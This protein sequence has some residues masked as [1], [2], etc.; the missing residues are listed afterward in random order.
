MFSSNEVF[1]ILRVP[2]EE[3]AFK[4]RGAHGGM[5]VLSLRHS[6]FLGCSDVETR[7][8]ISTTNFVFNQGLHEGSWLIEAV[9]GELWDYSRFLSQ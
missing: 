3:D 4:I 6:S 9:F 1:Q 7:D 8:D 5:L 2:G